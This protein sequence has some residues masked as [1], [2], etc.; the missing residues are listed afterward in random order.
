MGNTAAVALST[1]Q[2]ISR[3]EEVVLPEEKE[4]A[5]DYFEMIEAKLQSSITRKMTSEQFKDLNVR[6]CTPLAFRSQPHNYV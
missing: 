5:L 1:H 3:L 6:A 4:T 2:I